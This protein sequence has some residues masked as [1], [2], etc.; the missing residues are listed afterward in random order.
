[1]VEWTVRILLVG[2]PANQSSAGCIH[3]RDKN[4]RKVLR[5]SC[6]QSN[7]TILSDKRRMRQRGTRSKHFGAAYDGACVCFTND[8]EKDVGNFMHRTA[9]IDRRIDQD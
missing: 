7:G 1:M 4:E 2:W 5:F 9:A 8:V 3:R 6:F